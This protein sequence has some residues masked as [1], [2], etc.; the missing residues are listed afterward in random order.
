MSKLKYILHTH[1]G[2]FAL[3][4]DGGILY[5]SDRNY[6]SDGIGWKILGIAT[7]HNSSYIIPLEEAAN[8]ANI[9]Q[10]W[11]HDLDHGTHRM[12]GSP[13]YRRAVKVVIASPDYRIPEA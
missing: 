1:R 6:Y 13:S 3:A 7:R 12:W 5:D 4:A 11:I 9:G 10:G 2:Y 8:G